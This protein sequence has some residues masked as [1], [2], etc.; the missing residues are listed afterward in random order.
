MSAESTTTASSDAGTAASNPLAN[1]IVGFESGLPAPEV[2][3]RL[4]DALKALRSAESRV[5]LWFA[6]VLQRKLFREMGY[7][8]IFQYAELAL[9]FSQAKT[10]QFMK[11]AQSLEQLPVLREEIAAERMPWTKA[12]EIVKVASPRT[13]RR[14]IEA[15]RK[16]SN[17]KL[18]REVSKARAHCRSQSNSASDLSQVALPQ[19]ALN[20]PER[21]TSS[22]GDRDGL[23]CDSSQKVSLS[24]SPEDFARFEALLEAAIKSRRIEG[25]CRREAVVLAALEDMLAAPPQ[26]PAA[27]RA[28]GVT[29]VKSVSSK[30]IIIYKC[31]TCGGGKVASSRGRL[32][33]SRASL[34]A[35]ECDARLRRHPGTGNGVTGPRSRNRATIPP[36]MRRSVLDRDGHRCQ[37]PACRHTR[38]LEVHHIKSRKTGGTNRVENLITLCSACHK[39]VH[40]MGEKAFK[41]QRPRE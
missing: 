28:R 12:R 41:L 9:G 35:A 40:E 2:H 23:P 16:S 7:S 14:W 22:D 31:E 36:T 10:Y 33:L 15:A 37:A 34:A 1:R 24:F 13:E 18:E 39:L 3:A 21:Q 4:T 26:V 25:D 27:N 30:Q 20:Q 29:R 19:E 11:L 5:V 32:P 17:R 6:E 38:F 8:S